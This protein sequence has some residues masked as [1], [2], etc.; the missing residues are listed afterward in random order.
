MRIVVGEDTRV[1]LVR[2]SAGALLAL[3]MACTHFG[4][5]LGFDG[6]AGELACP[7]HG[8]RFGLDGAVLEGPADEPLE[9]WKVSE[10]GGV[11][12]VELGAGVS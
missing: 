4:S 12:R 10:E 1:L 5:D 7:S 2:G 11:I 8:S 6:A 9:T 3:S